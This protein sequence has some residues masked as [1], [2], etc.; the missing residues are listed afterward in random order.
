M[1][2][3]FLRWFFPKGNIHKKYNDE[4]ERIHE[5][6][7]ISKFSK[8][9]HVFLDFS[10]RILAITKHR[11]PSSNLNVNISKSAVDFTGSKLFSINNRVNHEADKLT[12]NSENISSHIGEDKFIYLS[13]RYVNPKSLSIM[14]KQYSNKTMNQLGNKI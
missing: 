12:N 6:Y 14:K 1:R 4:Q 10:L 13:L 11:I 7:V 2:R 8:I 5:S 3:F 9:Y